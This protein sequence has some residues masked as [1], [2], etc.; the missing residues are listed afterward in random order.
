MRKAIIAATM[1]ALTVPTA[2][3]TATPALAKQRHYHRT[4]NGIRYWRG[5][6]G[7]YY[8]KKSDGTTGLL[9]GGV[10]G[11]L[12]GRA[13]DGGRDK[14]VGTIVGAGAGA[15]LGREIDRNSSRPARCR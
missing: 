1:A 2:V 3:V 12:I 14:T 7:R 11:A 15:L 9:I 6:N 4:D 13:I 10:A 5:D 8:C